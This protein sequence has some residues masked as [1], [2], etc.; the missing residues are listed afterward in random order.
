M[1]SGW[2][3]ALV[4]LWGNGMVLSDRD[5][6]KA[7]ESGRIRIDPAPD[8]EKQLGSISVDFTLGNTFMVFEQSRFSY[9]DPRHPQSIGEAMRTI[10]VPDVTGRTEGE[11]RNALVEA[12]FSA[13]QI[14]TSSVERDD[15][16]PGTVVGTEPGTGTAVGAGEDIVLLVAVPT[17]PEPTPT[18]PAPTSTPAT[19]SP[20]APT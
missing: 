5:I 20:A 13:G 8:L 10:E 11:A 2:R 4:E 15:V 7:L 9:I 1:R 18:T 16:P 12:G 17:P 14:S 3:T 6:R 19:S